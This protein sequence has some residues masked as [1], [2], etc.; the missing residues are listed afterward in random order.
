MWHVRLQPH[1][2]A[3][4]TASVSTKPTSP[5]H[6][7]VELYS[8]LVFHGPGLVG[9]IKRELAVLLRRDGFSSVGDAV[10][11]DQ[12]LSYTNPSRA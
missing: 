5:L 12:R 8:A 7:L 4:I 9:R 1:F 6:P 10:G 2:C 11:A 3:M